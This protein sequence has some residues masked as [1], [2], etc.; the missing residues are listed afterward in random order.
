[1]AGKGKEKNKEQMAHFNRGTG[2]CLRPAG[3]SDL[4]E[5]A[6]IGRDISSKSL[7]TFA[8]FHAF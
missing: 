4:E 1:M 5:D 3:A 7:A 2:G 6:S 8:D